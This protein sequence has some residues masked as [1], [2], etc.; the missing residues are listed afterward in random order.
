M[1]GTHHLVQH[2]TEKMDHACNR[3]GYAT[4]EKPGESGRGSRARYPYEHP[5]KDVNRKDASEPPDQH[6]SAAQNEPR[7]KNSK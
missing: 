6:T 3:L 5:Y 7:R 2:V 4:S 1:T